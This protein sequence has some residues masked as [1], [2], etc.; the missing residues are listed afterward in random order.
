MKFKA[1]IFDDIQLC[2]IDIESD[3][4]FEL[5]KKVN[6]IGWLFRCFE[7]P[8]DIKEY[9]NYKYGVKKMFHVKHW[10]QWKFDFEKEWDLIRRMFNEKKN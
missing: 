3:S 2:D 4:L 1:I 8:E 6:E 9:L 7:I 10:Q 5:E